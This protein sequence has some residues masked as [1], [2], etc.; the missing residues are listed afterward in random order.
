M[1]NINSP[2]SRATLVKDFTVLS[3][4]MPNST[5]VTSATSI[6]EAIRT[7]SNLKQALSR[8]PERA[9]ALNGCID[10]CNHVLQASPNDQRRTDARLRTAIRRIGQLV[11]HVKD[12]FNCQAYGLG[13]KSLEPRLK[14]NHQPHNKLP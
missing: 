6:A 14:L 11:E 10:F 12:A 3:I 8:S 2:K 13:I 4:W 1:Q 9:D 7:S 5:E